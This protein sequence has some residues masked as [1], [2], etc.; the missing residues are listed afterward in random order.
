MTR[1]RWGIVGRLAARFSDSLSGFAEMHL[2]TPLKHIVN[3]LPSASKIVFLHVRSLR[4]VITV[5]CSK[6]SC[7]SALQ[8]SMSLGAAG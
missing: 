1:A 3:L 4:A 7:E 8:L 6:R 5:T 2:I